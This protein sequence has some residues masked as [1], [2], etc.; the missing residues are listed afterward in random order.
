MAVGQ[1]EAPGQWYSAVILCRVWR[2]PADSRDSQ[3]RLVY[4]ERG[5]SGLKDQPSTRCGIDGPISC[6]SNLDAFLQ[7]LEATCMR[8]APR[9]KSVKLQCWNMS[10]PLS[11]TSRG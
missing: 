5:V 1:A 7:A 2:E 8:S 6:C 9:L 3:L 11:S 4:C 10:T